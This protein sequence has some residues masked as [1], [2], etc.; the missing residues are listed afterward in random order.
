MEPIVNP[1]F[2]DQVAGQL[3][4]SG[5]TWQIWV[6]VGIILLQILIL[7]GIYKVGNLLLLAHKKQ[8]ALET[9]NRTLKRN[10]ELKDMN[11]HFAEEINKIHHRIDEQ[12]TNWKSELHL[13]RT[14]LNGQYEKIIDLIGHLKEKVNDP[15]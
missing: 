6:A 2:N 10:A 12:E 11:T 9:E 1:L 5:Q 8:E 15:R 3:I 7:P 14:Q 13:L 4:S